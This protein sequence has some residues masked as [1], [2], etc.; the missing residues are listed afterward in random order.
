MIHFLLK[1]YGK[2]AFIFEI[3]KIFIDEKSARKWEEIVI[4]KLALN[5]P[6]FLNKMCPGEKIGFGTGDKNPMKNPE[7]IKRMRQSYIKNCM[8]N[9]GVIHTNQLEHN[10]KRLSIFATERNRKQIQCPNCMK[11]GGSINMVR[12]HF[13]KCKTVKI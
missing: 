3:R 2:N 9:Y 13:N 6:M 5:H 1:K 8:D 10:R 7:S 4:R 12:Y 11:I